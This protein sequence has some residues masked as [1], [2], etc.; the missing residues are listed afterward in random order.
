[1]CCRIYV[2]AQLLAAV[3]SCSIFAFVSGWGPLMPLQSM[4]ALN[5]SWIESLWMWVTGS[6]PKRFQHSGDENI[7]D[8]MDDVRIATKAAQQRKGLESGDV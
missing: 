6:P 7:N 8:V 1:M 3:L 2:M 4:Q 5:L